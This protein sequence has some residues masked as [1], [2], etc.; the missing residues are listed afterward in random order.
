MRSYAATPSD[1]SADHAPPLLETPLSDATPVPV[2]GHC[3]PRFAA[4]RETFEKSVAKQEIGASIAFA[5]DGELVVDLWG[6]YTSK[7]H[8]EPWGPDT[9]ANTYSTTK[10][11]TAL[12]AHR[13]VEQGKIDLDAPVAE[14]WPEFAAAG[15]QD[16]PV[17]WL[18]CHRVGLP[19]VREYRR[20]G[21]RLG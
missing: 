1:C 15:K 5:L 2:D 19:A 9:I 10:G 13:L 12:I 20:A 18:L 4:V 11:M 21:R 7:D 16:V 8:V 6:G 14:Y 3:D 17:S